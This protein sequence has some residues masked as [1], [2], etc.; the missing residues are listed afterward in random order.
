MS[1]VTLC[2]SLV[3]STWPAKTDLSTDTELNG[4]Y[5]SH[6]VNP[7]VLATVYGQYSVVIIIFR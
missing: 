1:S 7:P 5:I 3:L 2:P 4:H 6:K